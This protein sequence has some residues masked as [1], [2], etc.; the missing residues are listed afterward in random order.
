MELCILPCC[1]AGKVIMVKNQDTSHNA[2][3]VSAT[4]ILY[5]KS[6]GFFSFL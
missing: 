6:G 2:K 4:I 3:M 1:W 5:T